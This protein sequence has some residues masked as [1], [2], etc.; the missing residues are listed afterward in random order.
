MRRYQEGR[1]IDVQAIAAELGLG[2]TTIYRWFGSRDHLI[3]HVLIRAAAPRLRRAIA[4]AQGVGG[5]RL[6]DIFDRYNRSLASAPTLAQFLSQERET[7]LRVI[8][9]SAGLVHRTAVAQIK[10]LIEREI[11]AGTYTPP[12]DAATLGYAI[13][14]LAEAFLFSDEQGL[15]ADVERLRDVE[16]ALLGVPSRT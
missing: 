14:R 5:A 13:V 11:A 10:E 3:A 15:R 7:A 4:G 6:L 1:R 9:A 12:V 2:R 16:A 8:T